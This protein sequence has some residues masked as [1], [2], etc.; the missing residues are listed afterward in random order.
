MKQKTRRTFSAIVLFSA[1]AT[2]DAAVLTS[3][4]Q[5][6]DNETAG[7][8]SI[9]EYDWDIFNVLGVARNSTSGNNTGFVDP[10]AGVTAGTTGRIY[11]GVFQGANQDADRVYFYTGSDEINRSG[12][13]EVDEISFWYRNSGAIS[14][15]IMVETEGNWYLSN[16]TGTDSGTNVTAADGTWTQS[17]FDFSALTWR[18][19]T[20][21]P[22]NSFSAP[23]PDVGLPTGNLTSWAIYADITGNNQGVRIDDFEITTI[24]EPSSMALVLIIAATNGTLLVRR[25]INGSRCRR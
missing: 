2:A 15:Q 8:L 11:S 14:Y 1:F 10:A 9:T 17:T 20:A 4:T 13:V 23:G 3:Y 22:G 7:P 5:T 24:P 19:T 21:A 25:R 12:G 18:Q 16:E 6:F